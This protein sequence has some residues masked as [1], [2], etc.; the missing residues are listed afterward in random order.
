MRLLHRDLLRRALL[1]EPAGA[2]IQALGVFAHDD[3]VDVLRPFVLQRRL[4][5]GVE[6]HRAQ[7][8]VEVELEAQAQEHAREILRVGHPRVADRAEQDRVGGLQLLPHLI[9]DRHAGAQVFVGVDLEVLELQGRARGTQHLDG[10][11][12][13][14]LPR[15][16]AWND[17]D[18]LHQSRGPGGNHAARQIAVRNPSASS[19]IP[20]RDDIRTL[21]T[22]PKRTS[23]P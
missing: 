5:A 23:R 14:L 20:N 13:D 10:L 1:Q 3:E 8:D 18:L 2:G 22:S 12:D 16:V 9:G 7:V 11:G 19:T 21:V 15:P 17:R 6:L 4:D